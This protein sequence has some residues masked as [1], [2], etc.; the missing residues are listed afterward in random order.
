MKV[1][2]D[3]RVSDMIDST[4]LHGKYKHLHWSRGNI[5]PQIP[6]LVIMKSNSCYLVLFGSHSS[7]LWISL[8]LFLYFFYHVFP[9]EDVHLF[10]EQVV[11]WFVM[12]DNDVATRS[13]NG[14]LLRLQSK[15]G[16]CFWLRAGLRT[17]WPTW[18]RSQNQKSCWVRIMNKML[19][20]IT[21]VNPVSSLLWVWYMRYKGQFGRSLMSP[22]SYEELWIIE[23]ETVFFLYM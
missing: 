20:W 21:S 6:V 5:W 8:L 17:R 22:C 16:V 23:T 11:S 10:P 13:I 19:G 4:N 9:A 1:V 3:K 12:C 14:P 18:N 7:L 2:N 15:L